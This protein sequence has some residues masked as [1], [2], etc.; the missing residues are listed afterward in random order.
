MKTLAEH[1]MEKRVTHMKYENHKEPT[2]NG[3]ECPD[4]GEELFDLDSDVLL[5]SNPPMYIVRCLSCQYKSFR[6]A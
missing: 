3:L 2:R 6:F 5:L 4:C 1:N